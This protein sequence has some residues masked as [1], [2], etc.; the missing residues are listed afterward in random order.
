MLNKESK[1]NEFKNLL[2]EL[3]ELC[4]Q[5]KQSLLGKIGMKQAKLIEMFKEREGIIH[6][7]SNN[8]WISVDDE[9]P[10]PEIEY[11]REFKPTKFYLVQLKSGLIDIVAFV[12]IYYDA[13]D[14]RD[15]FV[16]CTINSENNKYVVQEYGQWQYDI[17]E[18]KYWQH[19]PEPPKE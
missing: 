7:Q 4:S 12:N 13:G 18:V 19:L 9:L 10:E 1:V 11:S 14:N 17:N 3:C 6:N 15:E 2:L 8:G 5:N 16:V